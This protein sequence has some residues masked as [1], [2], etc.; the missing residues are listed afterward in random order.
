M[1]HDDENADEN[2]GNHAPGNNQKWIAASEEIN[3][4]THDFTGPLS[5]CWSLMFFLR[6]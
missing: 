5:F 3:K 6:W 2:Q 1:D 4:F